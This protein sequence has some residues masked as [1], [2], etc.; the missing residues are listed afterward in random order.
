MNKKDM[1]ASVL[2]SPGK[3]TYKKIPIPKIKEDEVL[4]QVAYV[5]VCG[6]DLPRANIEN[7]ARKYPLVLGHEFS[8]VIASTGSAVKNLNIGDKVAIAPLIPDPES[9]YTKEALYGLSDNYTIIGTGDNGAF[10]EY[11][12]VPQN[13]IV[14]I[15]PELDLVTAAGVEPATISFH[16]LERAQ[17][18][19]GDTVAVLGCGAIGQF[20]IQIAKIFG[21]KKVI[22]IDIID[23]KLELAKQL[24]ADII[25]NSKTH[26]LEEE[27]LKATTH[28][29]HVVIETAGSKFTQAQS[30]EIARKNASI[31]FVGISHQELHLNEKQA[32]KIM[33]AELNIRGSWNSYTAP[34][35]GRAWEITLHEMSK[36]RIRFKPMISHKVTLEEIG[37]YLPKMYHKEMTFNKVLVEVN[38][39]LE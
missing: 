14:P 10:A 2:V 12:K 11:V 23:E 26:N 37:E 28:G 7:G 15:P 6:S 21:A 17:M 35:P 34:Y 33:R 5:G 20:A 1:N 32:E 13:H 3:L 39:D 24:G 25:I 29:V 38:K 31:V 4:V 30:I 36:N 9:I 22:A 16:A 8:G 27:I 19:V 18:N